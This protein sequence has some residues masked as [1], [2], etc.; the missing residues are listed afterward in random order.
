MV[1]GPQTL[2]CPLKLLRVSQLTTGPKILIAIIVVIQVHR[3]SQC[4][5]GV[6]SELNPPKNN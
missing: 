2:E 4:E 3:R 1:T 5:E 6:I